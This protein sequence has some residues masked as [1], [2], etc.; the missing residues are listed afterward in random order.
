MKIK[1][2]FCTLVVL[3]FSTAIFAQTVTIT[4]KK[5]VYTRKAKSVPKEKRT[6]TVTYPVVSGTMSPAVKK[7]L[8][9]SISYWRTFETTLAENLGDYDWLY[10]LSYKVNYNKNGILDIA[11]TQ[12]GSGAYPDSQTIVKVINLKTGEQAKL[13]DVFKAD[14]LPKLAAMVDKKLAAEKAQIIKDINEGKFDEGG[15]PDKEANDAVK[16]QLGNLEFTTDSF[17]QY[18]VSDKGVTFIYDADFPHVIQAAQ[19]DGRYFFTWAEL[20]PFIKPEGLLGQ[21]IR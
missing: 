6:F 11:L 21:F 5:N 4:P 12:D 17:D 13:T 20:K 14:S 9:N 10:E 1:I 15:T 18:S 2:F 3:I 16:E 19:P 8:E 7:K